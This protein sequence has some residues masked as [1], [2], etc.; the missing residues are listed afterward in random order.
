[1]SSCLSVYNIH[2]FLPVDLLY[3]PRVR[4]KTESHLGVIKLKLTKE[5]TC[6]IFSHLIFDD[7]PYMGL[8]WWRRQ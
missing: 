7:C 6:L 3:N 5:N 8:P 2:R 4:L 1:M